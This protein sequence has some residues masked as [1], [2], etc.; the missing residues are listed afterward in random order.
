M[1][2]HLLSVLFAQAD[3][4]VDTTPSTAVPMLALLLASTVPAYL[5]GYFLAK[6]LKMPD[7]AGKLGFIGLTIGLGIGVIIACLPQVGLATPKFGIDLKGGVILVYEINEEDTAAVKSETGNR[8]QIKVGDLVSALNERLNPGGVNEIQIRAYGER[9][10]EIVVP[11]VGPEEVA[12]IKYQVENAGRLEFLMLATDPERDDCIGIV[13]SD[14]TLKREKYI[15]NADGKLIGK[16]ARV[17]IETNKRTG[18]PELSVFYP[19]ATYRDAVTGDL[20]SESRTLGEQGFIAELKKRGIT[21]IDA[22]MAVDPDPNNWVEGTHLASAQ[23][24]NDQFGDFTVNFTMKSDG[25]VRMGNLTGNNTSDKSRGYYRYMGIVLDGKLGSAPSINSMISDNGQITGNFSQKEVE[26]LVKLLRS[27]KLPAVLDPDPISEN[28]I[29]P[30]LGLDTINKGR[31]SI[32][33]SVVAVLVFMVM[34]YRFAGVVACFALVVNTLLVIACMILMKAAFTLPGLAGMVLT[35]GMSVDANVLIYERI[36]EELA[37]GA[38]LRMAI[39][40]GFSRA[41][42]SIIDG[43]LTTIITAVV[44]Y[45]IGGE[46]LKG[47][48]VTLILGIVMSMYTAIFC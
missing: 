29:S 3:A 24:G 33:V 4:A 35:V 20:L 47:F 39:R 12:S 1:L 32:I 22:L 42:S 45:V 28:Q 37:R 21:A 9:Q 5:I 11:D 41:M 34:Y 16:W 36:R 30:L 38:A 19:N 7:Y 48:A 43:N 17:S 25:A 10:V 18:L 23:I 2:D 44:L 6:Q 15:R 13:Q 26:D 31:F 40:N 14:P 27:G 8:E 46:Q